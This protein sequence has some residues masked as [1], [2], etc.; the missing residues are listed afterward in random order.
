MKRPDQLVIRQGPILRESPFPPED[1]G[2]N[3]DGLVAKG[4]ETKTITPIGAKRDRAVEEAGAVETQ[5][6]SPSGDRRIFQRPV[7][8]R[9]GSF[10]QAAIG[11]QYLVTVALLHRFEGWTAF[12]HDVARHHIGVNYLDTVAGK[13]IRYRR[14]T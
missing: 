13:Q 10:T 4:A 11:V 9:A 6:E 2:P 1:L 8:L 7:N 12:I 3:K 5:P 14:F